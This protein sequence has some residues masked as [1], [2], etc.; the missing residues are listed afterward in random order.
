V[1]LKW[2]NR[3]SATSPNGEIQAHRAGGPRG[4]MAS[5]AR[6]SA[7]VIRRHS[8]RGYLSGAVGCT[9]RLVGRRDPLGSFRS[10]ALGGARA[11]AWPRCRVAVCTDPRRPDRRPTVSKLGEEAAQ[12]MRPM[13]VS[14]YTRTGLHPVSGASAFDTRPFLL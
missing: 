14:G 1:K 12:R 9:S 13:L 5:S 8:S 2:C 7:R 6:A 11:G 10:L 3:T 4:Q